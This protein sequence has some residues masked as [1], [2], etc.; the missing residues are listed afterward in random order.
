MVKQKSECPI[1]NSKLNEI[2]SNIQWLE[3][4]SKK[5]KRLQI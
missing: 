2:K 1:E 3:V 4:Q 5:E